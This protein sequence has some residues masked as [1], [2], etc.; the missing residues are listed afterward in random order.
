MEMKNLTMVDAF[1][2][3]L[4]NNRLRAIGTTAAHTQHPAGSV[5]EISGPAVGFCPFGHINSSPASGCAGNGTLQQIAAE[6]GDVQ[7]GADS[8]GLI[9]TF[10]IGPEVDAIAVPLSE[11]SG[12]VATGADCASSFYSRNGSDPGVVSCAYDLETEVLSGGVFSSRAGEQG[13]GII[14][15]AIRFL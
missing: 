9:G 6:S 1:E 2:S 14:T 3:T 8:G 12:I 13:F 15:G 5:N 10:T 7:L 4:L 11:V